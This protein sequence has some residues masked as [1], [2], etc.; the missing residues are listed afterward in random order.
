MCVDEC[1][2]TNFVYLQE[3]TYGI[4]GDGRKDGLICQDGVDTS[5]KV[6]CSLFFLALFILTFIHVVAI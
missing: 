1:P 6:C 2:S 3:I 4:T 5:I